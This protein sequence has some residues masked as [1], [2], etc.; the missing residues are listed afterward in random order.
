[1][2]YILHNTS[3]NRRFLKIIFILI[4]EKRKFITIQI[5]LKNLRQS[6]YTFFFLNNNIHLKSL[7][8]QSEYEA[9]MKQH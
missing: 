2:K 4:L 3:L 5:I 1:M 8:K 6:M 7:S 9:H